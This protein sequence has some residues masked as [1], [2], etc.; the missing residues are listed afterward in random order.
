MT[1]DYEIFNFKAAAEKAVSDA[2]NQRAISC[3]SCKYWEPFP[4]S[5]IA[6]EYHNCKRHAGVLFG[7]RAHDWCSLFE[8]REDLI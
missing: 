8:F 3:G 5:S 6:P 2:V 1:K 7:M 4:A